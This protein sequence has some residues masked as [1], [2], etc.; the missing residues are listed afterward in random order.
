MLLTI[1]VKSLHYGCLMSSDMNSFMTYIY[2]FIL[3]KR[4][5][6]VAWLG[7][8]RVF[9]DGSIAVLQMQMEICK[10]GRRLKIRSL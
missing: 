1:F 6:L 3:T 9:A 4:L 7:P 8:G 5:I 2:R 10:D